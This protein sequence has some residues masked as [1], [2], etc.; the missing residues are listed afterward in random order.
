MAQTNENIVLEEKSLE[1]RVRSRVTT[2]G[3]KLHRNQPHKVAAA[4]R[5]KKKI[6]AKAK[7]ADVD[8][9]TVEK[10]LEKIDQKLNKMLNKGVK[11]AEEM[12][13]SEVDYFNQLSVPIEWKKSTRAEFL[14]RKAMKKKKA[15]K[16]QSTVAGMQLQGVD[17]A[18][19][20]PMADLIREQKRNKP[21]KKS[22]S[23]SSTP[24][25]VIGNI[26][27]ASII[28]E[29]IERPKMNKQIHK[30]NILQ[31]KV[32]KRAV[33]TSKK[34]ADKYANFKPSVDDFEDPELN[35]R[36]EVSHFD[37][38]GE[39]LNFTNIRLE[40]DMDI[41]EKS[42]DDY[43]E[44]PRFISQQE[45][46]MRNLAHIHGTSTLE[47]FA[48]FP[49]LGNIAVFIYQLYVASSLID[50]T[51]A[52]YQFVSIV[53]VKIRIKEFVDDFV[54]VTSKLWPPRTESLAD[55]F[56]SLMQSGFKFL[57]GDLVLN[58]RK[59]ILQLVSYKLFTKDLAFNIKFWL[60]EHVPMSLP[61][62]LQHIGKS[63]VTLLRAGEAYM[64]GIP[65]SDIV[66]SKHPLQTSIDA[67]RHLLSK[68]KTLYIG[69]P[70]PGYMAQ[71]E[72]I[73]EVSKHVDTLD[74]IIANKALYP[75]QTKEL[76]PLLN[77]ARVSLAEEMGALDGR[78][79]S[80]PFSIIFHGA[81]GT[82]KSQ[83]V[84]EACKVWCAVKGYTFDES[85][86]FHKNPQSEYSEGYQPKSQLFYHLSELGNKNVDIVKKQGDSD[87]TEFCSI[88]DHLPKTMNMAFEGK[89][90]VYALFDLVVVDTNNP[91]LNLKYVV[92]NPA[93]VMRRSLYV[94]VSVRAEYRINDHIGALDT[95][96]AKL[97]PNPYD[98]WQFTVTRYLPHKDNVGT[99]EIVDL[100]NVN[101]K[102]FSEY[103]VEKYKDHIERCASTVNMFR[104]QN[105][106][107]PEPV[108]EEKVVMEAPKQM[109][110]ES[111]FEDVVDP[112]NTWTIFVS[113]LILIS[114]I[115]Y[116][117]YEHMMM[118]IKF[119]SAYFIDSVDWSW[120]YLIYGFKIFKF[121]TV[122]T[123]TYGLLHIL[124]R[125]P[126]D[127]DNKKRFKDELK[128]YN[129]YMKYSFFKRYFLRTTDDFF[130]S[131]LERKVEK[132]ILAIGVLTGVY[133]L[134]RKVFKKSS[135]KSDDT[136]L[137]ACTEFKIKSDDNEFLNKFEEAI[138]VRHTSHR[139]GHNAAE[140]ITYN[141][142]TPPILDNLLSNDPHQIYNLLSRNVRVVKVYN[143]DKPART[144]I[145]G[146]CENF[147]L[148]N[149]HVF[150]NGFD[151]YLIKIEVKNSEFTKDVLIKKKW[152][153]DICNDVAMIPITCERFKDI[154][155]Y[156]PNEIYSSFYQ[157][158]IGGAGV[159]AHYT[160]NVLAETVEYP[161]AYMYKWENHDKGVCGTPLLIQ[162]DKHSYAAAI[163][164][165]GD[166]LSSLSYACPILK[167]DVLYGLETIK[168]VIPIFVSNS[169]NIQL[170]GLELPNTKSPV[171]HIDL[172]T[173]TYLGRENKPIM[174]NKK[175][176]LRTTPYY[177]QVEGLLGVS[178]RDSEG[179]MLLGPPPMR[180]FTRDGQYY[181]LFNNALS[182]AHHNKVA[183]DWDILDL[184]V[185]EEVEYFKEKMLKPIS[186]QA[187]INGIIGDPFYKSLKISSS[188]GHGLPGKKS[189]Y[190][191]IVHQDAESQIREPID[192]LKKKIRS[193][194][195]AY[196]LHRAPGAIFKASPKDEARKRSK[197]LNCDTRLFYGGAT[198]FQILAKMLLG[199]IF[200]AYMEDPINS[201]IAIG[202]DMLGQSDEFIRMLKEFSD[203]I[204][205]GDFKAF[206]FTVPHD[207]S[208]TAA[209]VLE[210]IGKVIGYS[211]DA[212]KI[213]KGILSDMLY[214]IFDVNTDLFELMGVQP[215]GAY[216]TA[217][218]NSLKLRILIKYIFYLAAK[219]AGKN[220]LFNMFVK[221]A[222]YGDDSLGSVKKNLPF[223]FN[224]FVIRDIAREL[225]MEFTSAAKDGTMTEFVTVET[226]SFLKRN[227]R[228]SKLCNRIVAPLQL[229]S[230]AKSIIYYIPSKFVSKE[231]QLCDSLNSAL[232]EY[233]FH[234]DH[235]EQFTKFRNGIFKLVNEAFYIDKSEF[236]HKFFTFAR[237]IEDYHSVR[238]DTKLDLLS[239][240]TK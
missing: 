232:R 106:F 67:L 35:Q 29:A 193:R 36:G 117:L 217:E 112:T 240:H 111:A 70:V 97:A 203:N 51:A 216:G 3:G 129:T 98:V 114:G 200:T 238:N 167:N 185:K 90:K 237:M 127:S 132:A 88:V 208:V 55:D 100:R 26:T 7:E 175:S 74:A 226:C 192:V 180:P 205:E 89:G 58:L 136:E 120:H 20:I 66:M 87:V 211:S 19:G 233:F 110:L 144:R 162:V 221:L 151:E 81:A 22:A 59:I 27:P 47:L 65:I 131:D 50:Y 224:N 53:N 33:P 61:E 78:N 28:E 143:G 40:A 76:Y 41:D 95:Q 236:E 212:M 109:E 12:K 91:S 170:E 5:I 62:F 4:K 173:L 145:F 230:I 227:F 161:V 49:F 155:H 99:D 174:L 1:S 214:P 176:Q 92:N 15:Q 17:K 159:R 124:A 126:I 125:L 104:N 146:V 54:S 80:T 191:P 130:A 42:D 235:E 118:P 213:L 150:K 21:S 163:H 75:S 228:F 25:A 77:E 108:E 79:R 220:V 206:E 156:I 234:C 141:Y 68:K 14:K 184:I 122:H 94:E 182:K 57:C 219:R 138:E 101:Y 164:C 13:L 34:K 204:L 84:S 139:E 181:S 43:D 18:S 103:L 209:K 196:E 48:D 188:A 147:A 10:K 30:K 107:V 225:G 44:L 119:V 197:N 60:G 24:I 137:E 121:S 231:T 135:K 202:I 187:S 11:P 113:M 168:N 172:Q 158:I 157:G 178:M 6:L 207:I 38:Y 152:I 83:L 142:M 128:H 115:V 179:N 195:E 9:K 218:F 69:L 201:G 73:K 194:I 183:L 52:C 85:M 8:E 72:Y 96:K 16:F 134:S 215:S 160:R 239:L 37:L 82:G 123:V 105:G 169:P 189:D 229:E 23:A 198:D 116:H 148:I 46:E 63:I 171:R 71:R 45:V 39:D 64:S 2:V 154:L 223:I 165:A 102:T 32:Y 186:I 31:D 140:W 210:E 93:A 177:T 199:P 133:Y 149:K 166:R 86:I 190:L 153:I 222:C 56:E